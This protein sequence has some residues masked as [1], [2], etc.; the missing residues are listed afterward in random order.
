MSGYELQRGTSEQQREANRRNAMKSTG[1]RTKSGKK[2]SRWNSTRHGLSAKVLLIPTEDKRKFRR[3]LKQLR[4][5]LNPTS[6]VEELLVEDLAIA[7]WRKSRALR[8]E[9]NLL[10]EAEEDA[11]EEAEK[12]EREDDDCDDLDEDEDGLDEETKVDR[13]ATTGPKTRE[14]R[15]RFA[16]PVRD[17][18]PLC[19]RYEAMADRRL[20]RALARVRPLERVR[21][22]RMEDGAA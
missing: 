10:Q 8:V 20:T 22:K 12:A 9:R 21:K 6:V 3:L 13:K 5:E 17:A 14:K 18:V 7:Y 19:F 16:L 1:P 4:R 2:R 15:D 11:A